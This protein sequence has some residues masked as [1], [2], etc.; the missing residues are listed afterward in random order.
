MIFRHLA[1]ACGL[2]VSGS[3]LLLGQSQLGTGAISGSILDPS[4]ASVGG[5]IVTVTNN[6]NGLTRQAS[7]SNDGNFAVPVLPSGVY[8]VK[9]EKPG[10]R[11]LEQKD[12]LV[13]VGSTSTLIL[14]MELGAVAETVTVEATVAVDT[15]STT[16]S[17]L[18]DRTQINDL[19]INGRRADQFALLTPGVTRDGR[20][21]LLSYRGQSGVFNNFMVEGNDDNQAYFSE[22]RGRT[23]IASNISANAIQEF[24]VGKGA[25]QA[26]FGRAAGGSIN[27]VLRSGGNNTHG[28]AF[29]YYRDQ[30]FNAR[31]P[32]ASFRPDERRQQFGGSIGGPIKKDKLFYF[33]NY[34]QQLRNFPLVTE[35]LSNVLTVGRP[36]LPN[37]P[38]DAQR[39]QYERDLAAFN[40][41]TE[42]LRGRFPEGAPGNALPRDANQELWLIKSDYNIT[43]RHT[44]SVFFNHLNA[45]GQNAIQTPLVLGNVG[46]NGSDDVR[47]WS[48]NA[49]LTS[50]V[51]PSQVNEF[52]FQWGRNHEFQFGNEAPPQVFVGNFSFGRAS[53]LERPALPDER[54]LQ[55]IDN[56]SVLLGKHTIKFGG[57]INRTYDIIENPAN[58]GASYRYS[59][60]LVFGRDILNQT[61]NGNYSSYTQSFGRPGV[62]FT[63]YDYALFFQDQWKVNR[64]LT[65]NFGLRYDYQQFPEVQFPNPAIPE[66]ASFNSDLNNFGPRVGAA[67]DLTGDGK[68]VLRGGYGM[69]YART[70]NGQIGDALRNN[71][72]L[73]PN[74]ATVSISLIPSDP[75]A[76]KFPNILPAFPSTARGS[77]SVSRMATDF[78]RP[79]IQDMNIGIER[80]LGKFVVSGSFLYTKGEFLPLSFDTNLPAPNYERT[81]R[82]PDG[83]TFTVPF[84]A[85]VT[86]TA[87][88]QSQNINLSRPD[89]N[90]GSILVS[91]SIGESWYRGMF[92]EVKRRFTN[93]F[94][95]GASYTLA[96]AENY[97]GSGDGGGSGSESPF[98]GG[99]LFNQFD[100]ESNRGSAPTDQRHRFV[101]NG[102]WNLPGAQSQNA[103]VKNVV[104]GFRLSGIYTAESGRGLADLVTI[105]QLPFTAPD[106]AQWNGFG[107]ILGQGG[108]NFLPT[109]ERNSDHGEANYRLDLRLARDFRLGERAVLEVLGEAFNLFNT[110][111]FN[112]FGN[113]IYDAA[114]T[115]ATTPLATPVELRSNVN[116]R[117]NTNNSSQPDGTNARRFQIALRFRF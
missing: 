65:L 8:L 86:R 66:T 70:P 44:L 15:T 97:T 11:T 102:V 109:V 23:R 55:F 114:S 41:G 108:L 53:F 52:R 29:W 72:L 103:F 14:K 7:S 4:G 75:G 101:A 100:L 50:T 3:C 62:T 79:R 107:G 38:T 89:P 90:F 49:R 74:Q 19:P 80:Q 56:Y 87:S 47:I 37:N 99:R 13:T 43:D 21:G 64:R 33:F 36:S 32:L 117:R 48:A 39:Q 18:V 25:F 110:S 63:T 111:N 104:G 115:P 40:A 9:A 73:D 91:R 45:R 61:P 105:P 6:G 42:F 51:T 85:G 16:E 95:F 116:Y 10:F 98:G 71:G 27:A 94:Q 69:I 92:L 84:S 24:Q 60:A 88:G 2:L 54:K 22:A 46:R 76:P 96:K 78:E 17:S 30:N 106:G 35:D 59:N 28:D 58:F 112:G 77:A 113:T 81:Y 93:G 67:Y 82:T 1:A 34:D 83:Q 31:D 20:F 26:E 12:V 5:A 68:T 57:E